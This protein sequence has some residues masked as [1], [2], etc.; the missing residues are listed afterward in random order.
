MLN[1][2]IDKDTRI[3]T[4]AR[5]EKLIKHCQVSVLIEAGIL[6]FGAAGYCVT[7][8][9]LNYHAGCKSQM[10]LNHECKFIQQVTTCDNSLKDSKRVWMEAVY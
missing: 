7:C 6:T 8:P 9:V 5:G 1:S 2:H 4:V 10:L 3:L